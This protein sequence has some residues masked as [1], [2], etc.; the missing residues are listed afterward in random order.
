VQQMKH[1]AAYMLLALGGKEA[2]SEAEVSA[3]LKKVDVEVNAEQLRALIKSM[4]GKKIDE[5]LA[6]GEKKLLAVGGGGA[7]PA[8][9]GAAP[10]AAGGKVRVLATVGGPDVARCRR[11]RSPRRRRRR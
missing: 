1:L 9:G 3:L 11:R 4:E 2:P 6:E 5:V 7:A 10:A 8:A